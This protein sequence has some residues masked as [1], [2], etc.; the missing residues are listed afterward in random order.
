Y[1]AE[2]WYYRGNGAVDIVPDHAF[3]LRQYADRGVILYGNR[4]T[5]SAWSKLLN[6]SPIQVTREALTIGTNTFRGSD[7][8]AYFTWPRPDS[9]IASVAVVTG[10]GLAGLHATDANQYFAVRPGPGEI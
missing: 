10:T 3:D 1:D 2:V 6:D 5:N 8:A 7:L 9:E 4:T